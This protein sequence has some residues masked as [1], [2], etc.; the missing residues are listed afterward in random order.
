MTGVASPGQER[1]DLLQVIDLLGGTN[2]GRRQGGNEA[3]ERQEKGPSHRE[4]RA[5]VRE[6]WQEAGG[7][8]SSLNHRFGPINSDCLE[9]SGPAKFHRVV[10]RR[11]WP[12][13]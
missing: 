4:F 11:I 13:T 1:L 3:D 9:R 10:Q 7:N 8:S 2:V 6:T 12:P 5:G